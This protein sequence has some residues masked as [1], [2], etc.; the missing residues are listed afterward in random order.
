M[1]ID[2]NILL[3]AYF[4]VTVFQWSSLKADKKRDRNVTKK[5]DIVK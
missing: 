2:L 5:R 4:Y 1:S 3:F